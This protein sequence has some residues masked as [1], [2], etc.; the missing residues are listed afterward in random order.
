[1]QFIEEDFHGLL[2]Q[3]FSGDSGASYNDVSLLTLFNDRNEEVKSRYVKL[4]ECDFLIS[5]SSS[6]SLH[7]N[8]LHSRFKK[9]TSTQ[10]LDSEKSSSSLARA[11]Y[12]PWYSEKKNVFKEYS[13]YSRVD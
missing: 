9:L 10:V 6:S 11:Y 5:S 1:L 8:L 4:D 7:S 2:P 13:L 3:Y 12:I